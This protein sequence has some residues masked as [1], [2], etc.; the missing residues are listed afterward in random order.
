MHRNT[1]FLVGMTAGAIIGSTVG[2]M[3][4]MDRSTKRKIRKFGK[5]AMCMADDMYSHMKHYK[6]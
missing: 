4:N 5:N 3:M 2:T 6:R 1:K